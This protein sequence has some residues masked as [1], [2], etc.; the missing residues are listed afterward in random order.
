VHEL[1]C[2]EKSRD[3]RCHSQKAESTGGVAVAYQLRRTLLA[4]VYRPSTLLIACLNQGA[5]TPPT[6]GR[7]A[8]GACLV[9]PTMGAYARLESSW[10]LPHD[11]AEVD[12]PNKA[13]F[14]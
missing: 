1:L 7:L 14:T 2:G 10:Q 9:I 8:G 3:V 13:R 4:P 5:A 11:T 12:I 6:D